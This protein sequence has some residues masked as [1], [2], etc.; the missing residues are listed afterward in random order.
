MGKFANSN[1]D[2]E[3]MERA[4]CEAEGIPYEPRDGIRVGQ[5]IGPRPRDLNT[6]GMNHGKSEF[7]ALGLPVPFFRRSAAIRHLRDMGFTDREKMD[8]IV[9][10]MCS[11]IE[12]DDSHMA[13]EDA[14]K[15]GCDATA[16][17]RLLAVLLAEL[18]PAAAEA[19][20]VDLVEG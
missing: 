16:C 19:T 8:R 5:Y 2:F 9:G 10:A 20:F 4:A 1:D 6:A 17:Y 18:P 11:R 12:H 14:M 3:R 13:L 15:L 7:E